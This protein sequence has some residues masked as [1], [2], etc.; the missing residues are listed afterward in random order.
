MPASMAGLTGRAPRRFRSLAP[1]A[2]RRGELAAA[3]GVAVLLAHLLFAQLTLVLAVAFLAVGRVSRWH[4]LWLAVPAFAGLAW[5]LAIGPA[6]AAA[7]FTAGPGRVWAYLAGA[8]HQPGRVLH[9]LAGYGGAAQ[10]LPRQLPFA[11][12]AAAAEAAILGWLSQPGDSRQGAPGHRAGL[13]VAVRSRLSRAAMADGCAV[14]RDGCGVGLELASGRLAG[15]CWPEAAGGVLAV[16]ADEERATEL[17]MPVAA[18]A[19]RRRKAVLIIDL[20][21]AAAVTAAVTAAC[22][23]ADAPL[24]V[25][26][27]GAA[28][29]YEPFLD[30][31]LG[32]AARLLAEMIDWGGVSGQQRQAAQRYLSAALAVLAAGTSA[33]QDILAGLGGVLQPSGLRARASAL[34]AGDP[35]RVGLGQ[36]ADTAAGLLEADPDLAALLAAQLPVLSASPL[37]RGLW[38]SARGAAAGSGGTASLQPGPPAT[39]AA[40]IRLGHAVRDRQVVLFSLDHPRQGRAAAMVA[41]LVLADLTAVL[42]RLR[43]RD[44]SGDSLVWVNGIEWVSPRALAGLLA[45]APATGTAVLLSTARPEAAAG[46][47]PAARV[48]LAAGPAGADLARLLASLAGPA[49]PG[50][51]AGARPPAGRGTLAGP[52]PVAAPGS[53]PLAVAGPAAGGSGVSGG[54]RAGE[55][56]TRPGEEPGRPLADLLMR[57]PDRG[58]TLIARGDRARVL[59]GCLTIPAGP[60]GRP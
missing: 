57:Q 32:Q 35:R 23:L 25:F 36:Q 33:G 42:G 12:M 29:R 10:W 38:P 50:L 30:R 22:A 9:L 16:A 44:L 40:A 34:P 52:G 6:T 20:S 39:A 49:G 53:H 37:G 17:A 58:F 7:G 51:L 19:I 14:T 54:A 15:I 43:H 5:V 59:P 60:G 41:R 11:L 26:S 28:A 56:F 45:P 21:E 55:V 47:A 1:A 27:A 3:L 48:I 13:I 46:L 4:R 18:A 24:T 2:S 8:G 31:Q